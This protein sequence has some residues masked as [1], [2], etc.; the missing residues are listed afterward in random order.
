MQQFT[1]QTILCVVYTVALVA[2]DKRGILAFEF[3]RS[4]PV[5]SII[6]LWS[7]LK[8]KIYSNNPNT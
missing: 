5:R 6:Y 3:A 1:S 8:D 4:E 2:N 7:V